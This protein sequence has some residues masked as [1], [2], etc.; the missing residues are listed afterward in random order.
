MNK[1]AISKLLLLAA[2]CAGPADLRAQAVVL[3][4]RSELVGVRDAYGSGDVDAKRFV[5]LL[6][7]AGDKLL[8]KAPISITAKNVVPPSGDK[9]DYLSQSRYWWPDPS[10]PNGLPYVRRDGETN[11]EIEKIPDHKMLNET[12]HRIQILALCYFFTGK[13][14]YTKKA[15]DH[16][17]VWFLDDSTRMNPHM[18]FAQGVPGRSTGRG[19][20]VL[21]GRRFASLV[22]VLPILESS[23]EMSSDEKAK[24]RAWFSEYYTWLRTSKNGLE[25]ESA[26]NN[27]GTWYDVQAGSIAL[28][29]G[30][31]KE[32]S[33]IFERAKEKRIASGI[34][35]DGSQPKELARTASWDYSLFNLEA[36][37]LLAA[38]G[39]RAG[40]DLWN[41]E[42]GD[43][44]SIRKALDALLPVAKGEQKWTYKQ[45]RE[46]SFD[47]LC[48][49]LSKAHER[50]GEEGY[51][52]LA[53]RLSCMKDWGVSVPM[54]WK[55]LIHK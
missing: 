31:R 18:N 7:K 30:K 51:R 55:S 8:K 10:K 52:A 54:N 47:R 42:S 29:L 27:H 21:D 13:P 28:F 22:D 49:L 11:P 48:P 3:C 16:L 32:A 23:T 12:V 50:Y 15:A 36:L 25:E 39:D 26:E 33:A 24:L 14:E 43:G 20:G 2:I 1:G 9:R 34:E 4:G 38:L 40:V 45:I 41:Y 6:L 35:P 17:R 44:R 37:F 53:E 19:V 46:I 5:A